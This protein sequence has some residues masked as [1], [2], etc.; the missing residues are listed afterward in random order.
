MSDTTG[1]E[2][3]PARAKLGKHV[4]AIFERYEHLKALFEG[5]PCSP[6]NNP[7]FTKYLSDHFAEIAMRY[8]LMG[9]VK[10]GD[11]ADALKKPASP[12]Q[13]ADQLA[14]SGFAIG[15]AAATTPPADDRVEGETDDAD[16]ASHPAIAY[17]MKHGFNPLADA[18]E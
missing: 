9:T 4:G 5:K 10:E 8:A 7:E 16:F 15:S 1:P 18:E 11:E 12:E 13:R 3:S 6:I 2:I 14:A 17:A